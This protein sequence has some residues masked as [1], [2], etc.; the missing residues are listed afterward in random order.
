[1]STT[2]HFSFTAKQTWNIHKRET[3]TPSATVSAVKLQGINLMPHRLLNIICIN[4]DHQDL[5]KAKYSPRAAT[6]KN[7]KKKSMWPWPLTYDLQTQH[8]SCGCQCTCSRKISSSCVQRFVSYGAN[9]EKKTKTILSV[10]T[11]RTVINDK[12]RPQSQLVRRHNLKNAVKT[13]KPVKSVRSF[14]CNPRAIFSKLPQDISN[15]IPKKFQE[16]GPA[17]QD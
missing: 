14:T 10:D 12:R 15:D 8:A 2:F 16:C 4:Q 5:L 7:T 11:A 13:R 1:M 17:L 6:Q 9:R 3:Y